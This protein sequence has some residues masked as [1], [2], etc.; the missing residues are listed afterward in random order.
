MRIFL[1]FTHLRCE[2][3]CACPGA[4]LIPLLDHDRDY[5]KYWAERWREGLLFINVEQDVVPSLNA[6]KE[7]WNCPNP[8]CR[9]DY[10]YPHKPNDSSPIGCAKFSA[11]FI[12]QNHGLLLQGCTYHDPQ[13]MI[14]SASL[15]K[16]C[17]HQPP[18]LHL[19]IDQNWPLDFKRK[20]I[21]A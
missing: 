20:Y 17:V 18:A 5:G 19:H 14:I 8:Y 1:P 13:Y 12:A 7:M 2:T 21:H 10:C 6:M 15:N 3:F 9:L 11:Q 16:A 4:I